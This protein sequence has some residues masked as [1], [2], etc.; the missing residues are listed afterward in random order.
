MT[1]EAAIGIFDSGVGGLTVARAVLNVLPR[2]EIRYVG[3]T[4][5]TPYGEKDLETVRG[6]SL[7]IMDSLVESGVKMLVIA[8]NTAS[9]AVL[10]Q[11]RTR[12]QEEQGIP[13]VE[14]VQPAVE[15]AVTRSRNGKI[16]VIGTRAT[17]DSGVYQRK[18]S[19]MGAEVFTQAC[20]RFVE[21]AEEG[22]TASQELFDV[23]EEYLTPLKEAEVD[24]LVLGCTH[25]PLL[26][27]PISY[28]MGEN[29]SLISSSSAAARKVYGELVE[30]KML[31]SF[32]AQKA[33][34]HFI[35]TETK[36]S[37]IALASRIMGADFNGI[38]QEEIT[39]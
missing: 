10:D 17:I 1:N 28:F 21:F 14:V 7:S 25:Y 36:E 27:G 39:K 38:K 6:Y 37:F 12:Y 3:D 20:P 30:E 8:C 22:I 15:H 2:E 18:L 32:G 31:R 29:V 19:K 11:A 26:E 23:T 16:G 13:V 33:D 24:T 9:C 35:C 34:H 5:H 4:A